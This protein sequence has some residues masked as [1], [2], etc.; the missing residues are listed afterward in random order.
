MNK[1]I[2]L[3][4]AVCC[5][6][7][8]AATA[9]ISI[10]NTTPYTQ[11]FDGLPATGTSTTNPSPANWL[12][13]A[14]NGTTIT[15][16]SGTANSGG[17]YAAG[18]GSTT[19][20][21]MGMLLS[22]S[23]KPLYV[24]AKFVNNTGSTIVSAS[25]SYRCEQWRR[26]NTNAGLRDTL[27]V[28]YATGTDSVHLGTWTNVPALTGSSTN[29]STT[30][31]ALD[32]N[33]VFAT[34]TGNIT[35]MVI[36]DGATFWIRFND[37]DAFPGSDDML[38]IDDFSVSFTTGT[39][40]A[41]TEPAASVTNVVATATSTTAIS[42]SFTGVTA[43]GYL[44]LIDSNATVPTIADATAYT[45]GQTVGTATVI[46]NGT[47]TSFTKSGLV[48]NTIYKVHVFPYNNTSCTGGPNYKISAPANDTAK[49]L[50]DACPEPTNTPTNLV[51]TAV[52]NN[53]IDGKFN[54]SN[55]AAAGY[56]VVYS[57]SSNI[58]F[59]LDSVNYNVG[60]S[61]SLGAF[62]S[63]VGD[64]SSSANDT[65]FSI[66]GLTQ[67]TKYYVAVIPY[68]LCGAFK[69]YK[70]SS[71]NGVNRDDTTTAGTP[72]LVDC[73]Q[74]SGIST[75]TV[76][77]LDST[78]NSIT[79]KWKNAANA[80]SVMVIAGTNANIGFVTVRDSVYY[81][82]GSTIPG[83]NGI[84]YFRGTDST[85]TLTGLQTNTV[86][87]ILFATF[88]NRNCTNGPNYAN[89]PGSVTIRTAAGTDCQDPTGVSNTSIVK[90][91]STATTISIKWTNP[92]NSDSVMVVAAPTTVGFVTFRDSVNYPVGATI[93]SSTA[94]PARVYY[95]GTDSSYTLTG[96]TPNTVYKIFFVTFRNKNCTNGPNY[97]GAATTTIKT[98][99]STGVKYNNAEA[100]FS[101]FPNP[102]NSGS[103]FVKF[104]TA[105]REDAVIEVVDILGRKLSA[106]KISSGSA[107]Q[108]I[109]VSDFAKG[110]YLLNVIYKGSNNVSTFIVE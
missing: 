108:M 92:V 68:N 84:V 80:D 10:T 81:G 11:N 82:V 38:A 3:F 47:S 66:T 100:E 7:I 67:G 36:P 85:V 93:A 16:G 25:V 75:A 40:A 87:K 105:L 24:G 14:A 57:L 2:T 64:V 49:T 79:I 62:K 103:L 26:G 46:S 55:P 110:T 34:V 21:A 65:S 63:K 9:Q 71:S 109:D 106:Q 51:F 31:S 53:N 94:T 83:S 27:L 17:F 104:K 6:M 30:A 35:G 45:V 43:D 44:V 88:N 99:L 59:P 33:T 13:Y 89:N 95:R 29:T 107:M 60:D 20:R 8:S 91:D 58:G 18:T 32:G 70:R 52:G 54:K 5:L 98:A 50:L 23:A 90:L 56:V 69:N 48:Q 86:Y 4:V 1:R 22:T 15:A 76:V 28:D 19:E 39:V 78:T 72:P 73:V 37:F 41:C 74:P 101:L 77:N 97:S 96:L 61:I 12:R 102:T 42:G